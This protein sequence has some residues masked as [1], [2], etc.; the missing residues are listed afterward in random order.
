MQNFH[1]KLI[2]ALVVAKSHRNCERLNALCERMPKQYH[3]PF[4]KW[5]D[6]YV[7]VW[8]DKKGRIRIRKPSPSNG[9]VRILDGS[10]I[11]PVTENGLLAD[12][13]RHLLHKHLNDP[14]AFH[15]DP[16][17]LFAFLI[18]CNDLGLISEPAAS[19][20]PARWFDDQEVEERGRS[21]HTLQGGGTGL[22]R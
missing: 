6:R 13:L 10:E 1:E 20:E 3:Q 16:Y 14:L 12:Q 5:L 9:N 19:N 7:S 8:L 17:T 2:D 15:G 18:F 4:V 21:V 22:K 11:C